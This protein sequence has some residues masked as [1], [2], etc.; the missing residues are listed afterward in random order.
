MRR[1]TW[2][3]PVALALGMAGCVSMPSGPSSRVMPAPNKP[4]EVFVR[5][6]ARCRDYAHHRTGGMEASEAA[7]RSGVA[8]AAVGTV[9]GAAVGALAGGEQG[10]GAGA[11]GGL[12][13]GSASGASAAGASGWELQ[14]R[15]DIA[16][17]QCMYASGNQVPGY[18]TVPSYP[19]PPR[20]G[21]G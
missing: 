15:Y 16:Y 20:P 19:P 4:F 11:A 13:I 5:E 10:A 1:T 18:R 14:R 17:E 21:A 8:S 12:L 9:V 7:S 2:F 6:D 3:A